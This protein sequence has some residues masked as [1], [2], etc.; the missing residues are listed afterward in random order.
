M[1]NG[2]RRFRR[3]GARRV[4]WVGDSPGGN[5]T[6]KVLELA[7]NARPGTVTFTHIMHDDDCPALR[8][9]PGICNCNPDVERITRE[10]WI[11]LELAKLK[12]RAS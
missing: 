5:Y 3:A 10:E 1:S 6:Q 4:L 9:P 11:E 12:R 2:A 7:S 8:R